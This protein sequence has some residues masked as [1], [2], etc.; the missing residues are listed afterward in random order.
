MPLR[1]WSAVLLLFVPALMAMSC[2]KPVYVPL[3]RAV[4]VH[5]HQG[6]KFADSDLDLFFRRVASDS[7]CPKN[8]QCISAGEAVITLEARIMK[9]P[10]ETFDAKVAGEGADTDTTAAAVY[11]GYRVWVV[12]LEPYPVSGAPADT[13]MY[14][15]T[16]VVKQR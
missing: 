1:A 2:R 16:L 5:V 10:I 12:R 3:G 15:A 11:D 4:D 8:V 13:T 9:G 14:V 7:R 6:V